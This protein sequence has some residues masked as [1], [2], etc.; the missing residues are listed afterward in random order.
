MKNRVVVLGGGGHAAVCAEIL[1][2]H[3]NVELVGYTD[4]V[5]RPD[6]EL[7]YL[8]DDS[9]LSTLI[10]G[11]ANCVFV[12]LGSNHRRLDKID[13]IRGLGIRLISAV[14]PATIISPNVHIGDGVAIM[15]GAV[16]NARAKIGTGV[17]INTGATVDHDCVLGPCS[18]IGPGV[19]LAGSVEIG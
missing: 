17:V 8:G 13:Q 1:R 5:E 6:F 12:A 7:Q 14:N 18:H 10:G 4:P 19:N 15:S 11:I 16:V 3:G 2:A 9:E